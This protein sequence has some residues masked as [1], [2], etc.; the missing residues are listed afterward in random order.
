MRSFKHLPYGGF[1]LYAISCLALFGGLA[2]AAPAAPRTG[3]TAVTKGPA[4]VTVPPNVPPGEARRYG[5]GTPFQVGPRTAG[6]FCNLRV[7]GVAVGDF[8]DGTDAILF[9]DVSDIRADRAIPVTRNE[10]VVDPETGE[11]RIIV[12]YTVGCGFV[13]L[14]A[15]RA[16]GSA[17]PHAGTGFS[18]CAALS[19]PMNADGYFD[20]NSG[21]KWYTEVSQFIYDGK[22]LRVLRTELRTDK[23]PLKVLGTE[24]TI[25]D[26]GLT[27][28]I[29]DGEALLVPV[30]AVRA[31]LWACGVA[32]WVR[33]YGLWRP[34]SFLPVTEAGGPW[35]EPSLI[36]DTDGSLLFS[37]RG[38]GEASTTIRVWRSADAGATWQQII[39]APQTRNEA[40][41]VLN[42]AADGT[43]YMAGNL[44]GHGREVLCIW[45]LNADRSGLQEHIIIRDA[46]AEFGAS[47]AGWH[48]DHPNAVT[49]RL[50]D[51]QWHNVLAYRVMY[52]AGE[53]AKSISQ[54]GCYVEEVLSAG[55]AIPVWKF[56]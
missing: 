22:T 26:P 53:G 15:K 13:P 35:T 45:P 21:F 20:W 44:L 29:P 17:H 47:P 2:N 8:E 31:G 40:P 34:V 55:P 42:Q 5:L 41:I 39:D 25:M 19:F 23:H 38:Y 37:A 27:T 52:V 7:E 32:R 49:L 1:L 14:G 24:W 9:D 30:R 56:D 33:R 36:R 50:A 54:T 11:R 4:D 18:F 46:P 51:G 43:P 12:K 3:I 48:V 28:A 10:R 16:D 6:I